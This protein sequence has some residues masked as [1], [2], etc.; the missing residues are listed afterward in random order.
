MRTEANGTL[1][2]SPRLCELPCI[3]RGERCKVS[4]RRVL[5]SHEHV[6][7]S[8]KWYVPY[9]LAGGASLNCSCSPWQEKESSEWLSD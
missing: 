7:P 8:E 1:A 3:L 6:A 5:Y 2:Q 9:V 4:E